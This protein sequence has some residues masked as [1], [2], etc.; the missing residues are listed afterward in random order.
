M[1][2]PP[3][4]QDTT[5]SGLSSHPCLHSAPQ[6]VL[7]FLSLFLIMMPLSQL[8]NIKL[9]MAQSLGLLLFSIYTLSQGDLIQSHI[10]KYHPYANLHCCPL[11][12]LSK[13]PLKIDITDFS[14]LGS[15]PIP[16]GPSRQIPSTAFTLTVRESGPCSCSGKT[17]NILCFSLSLI[18]VSSVH[19]QRM[20]TLLELKVY[21]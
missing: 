9:P 15:N 6:T 20:S 11:P 5:F 10:I 7:S 8:I 3:D 21:P 17:G 12:W 4:F 16:H 1:T 19:C 14:N 13:C 2:S 18:C